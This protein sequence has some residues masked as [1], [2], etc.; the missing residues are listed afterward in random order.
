MLGGATYEMPA[1]AAPSADGATATDRAEPPLPSLSTLVVQKL[2]GAEM[3]TPKSQTQPT[4]PVRA[5]DEPRVTL[6]TMKA[7]TAPDW[8]AVAG[9]ETKSVRVPLRWIMLLAGICV[10]IAA[11]LVAVYVLRR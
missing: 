1:V 4:L 6:K 2:S 10:G 11:A 5:I 3:P 9:D 7:A 8:A